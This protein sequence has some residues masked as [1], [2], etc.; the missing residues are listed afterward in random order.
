M[1]TR[2]KLNYLALTG[3]SGGFS[4]LELMITIALV[5]ILVALAIPSFELISNINKLS[6][7]SNE[8]LTSLQVARTEAIRRGVHVVVC[9]STNADSGA[10]ATCNT[11]AGN[12]DGW[13]AFVDDG[14]GTPG[15]AK[16]GARNANETV[17]R[18]GR[19][20]PSVLLVPSVAVSGSTPAQTIIFRPDGLARTSSNALLTAQI[21]ICIITT[22]PSQNTRAVALAFGSRTSVTKTTDAT[23]TTTTN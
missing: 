6:G 3:S 5:G 12:W 2:S 18:V 16:N 8:L 10:A 19:N 23:C 1:Q 11:T 13:I 17:I 9:K 20:T 22:A 7:T 14:G 21:R 15:N 4:M